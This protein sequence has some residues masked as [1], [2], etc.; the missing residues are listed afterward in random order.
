MG[1]AANLVSEC[2]VS[3]TDALWLPT[4]LVMRTRH[5]RAVGGPAAAS[6]T[7]MKGILLPAMLPAAVAAYSGHAREAET[8]GPVYAPREGEPE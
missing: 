7:H 8:K 6:P 1:Y 4:R 3:E 5:D 2:R